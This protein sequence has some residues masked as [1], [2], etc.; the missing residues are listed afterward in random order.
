MRELGITSGKTFR[1]YLKKAKRI[2]RDR[3][4]ARVSDRAK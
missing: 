2:Q 4:A 3:I 1:R